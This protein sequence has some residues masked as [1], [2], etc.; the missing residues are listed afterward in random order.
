MLFFY[1][2]LFLNK[3]LISYYFLIYE[4]ELNFAFLWAFKL[5]FQ[6]EVSIFKGNCGYSQKNYE[7]FHHRQAN[8]THNLSF[9]PSDFV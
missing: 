5:Y 3:A 6:Y 4:R 8:N 7:I 2:F 9:I 1:L